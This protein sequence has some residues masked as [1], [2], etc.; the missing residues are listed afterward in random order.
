MKKILL[1][2]ML[3]CFSASVLANCPAPHTIIY[4]CHEFNGHKMCTWNPRLGWYQGSADLSPSLTEG[5][6][7][8]PRSFE[9]AI[10]FP[11]ADETHG[12]TTCYYR[13][14]EGERVTLFQQTGYGSVPPPTGNIWHPTTEA[15]FTGG[16]ECTLNTTACDFEFGEKW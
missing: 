11:Y 1:F 15:D 13:G 7:L 6:H 2:T 12:A 10:W 16:L 8:S 4:Q 14:P 5:D 9:K 3:T